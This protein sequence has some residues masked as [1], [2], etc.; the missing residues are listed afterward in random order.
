M[1]F[2]TVAQLVMHLVEVR[3]KG[4]L[5][6][7]LEGIRGTDLLTLNELGYAPLDI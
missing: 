6:K 3:D 7:G 4:R 5:K 2:Y 1:R